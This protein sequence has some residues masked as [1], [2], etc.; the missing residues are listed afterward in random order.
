MLP[1]GKRCLIYVEDMNVYTVTIRNLYTDNKRVLQVK[2]TDPMIAHKNVYMSEMR[3]DEEILSIMSGGDST[4]LF[5][6]KRGFLQTT[7]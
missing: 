5:D 1:S 3:N 2:D 6:S 4:V 7:S